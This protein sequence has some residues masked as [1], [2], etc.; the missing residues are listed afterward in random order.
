M[1]NT[2]IEY[3]T[4]WLS[5]SRGEGDGRLYF[6]IIPMVD[7]HNAPTTEINI[8]HAIYERLDNCRPGF[9]SPIEPLAETDL[10]NLLV[11][12][13]TLTVH[14]DQQHLLVTLPLP[15]S[16]TVDGAISASN[17]IDI[18]PENPLSLGVTPG[19]FQAMIDSQQ[20]HLFWFAPQLSAGTYELLYYV[21][22]DD[23][24]AFSLPPVTVHS[25]YQGKILA[26][27]FPEII[28]MY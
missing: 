21:T 4:P 14:T 13:I 5:V 17:T 20:Q 22:M 12:R 3:Q 24:Q 18:T 15:P 27:S 8:E 25:P 6:V 28:W 11:G 2:E 9:C 26:V 16:W 7:I 1:L 23:D 10:S 19:T